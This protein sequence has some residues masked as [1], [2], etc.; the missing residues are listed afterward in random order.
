MKLLCNKGIMHAN[1]LKN[2]TLIHG[3]NECQNAADGM[4]KSII[5]KDESKNR[6]SSL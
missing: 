2:N 5:V 6:V 4:T 1:A 3:R